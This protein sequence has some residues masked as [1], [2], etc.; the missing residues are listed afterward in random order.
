V[1]SLSAKAS[2]HEI[3]DHQKFINQDPDR[4][5]LREKIAYSQAFTHFIEQAFNGR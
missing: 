2:A 5:E 3:F 4:T 1:P